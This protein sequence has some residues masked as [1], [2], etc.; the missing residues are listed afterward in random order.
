MELRPALWADVESIL[1]RLSDQNRAEYPEITDAFK[2][3]MLAFMMEGEAT[4]MWFDGLPQAFLAINNSVTWFAG[5]N[6]YFEKG[7]AALRA[8]RQVMKEA[9]QRH[10]PIV[11]ASGSKHPSTAKW[12]KLMGAKS[13]DGMVF[14]FA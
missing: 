11:S 1:D 13:T 8:S 3:R 4:V 7:I 6:A 14:L 12:F 2:L 5:T 9:V 10:G